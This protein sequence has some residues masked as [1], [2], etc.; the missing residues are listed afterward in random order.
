MKKVRLCVLVSTMFLSLGAA[1]EEKPNAYLGELIP[2]DATF[3]P[4]GAIR[5]RL[6]SENP[7][8]PNQS[9]QHL[10]LDTLILGG[11]YDSPTVFGSIQWRFY[12]GSYP[13]VPANGYTGAQSSVGSVNFPQEAYLGYKLSQD[14]SVSAGIIETPFGIGRFWDSTFY[15]GLGN[16][17]GVQDAFNLGVKYSGKSGPAKYDVA[18]LAGDAGNFVGP[19]G[20]DRY[21]SN[22]SIPGYTLGGSSRN[23]EKSSIVGRYTYDLTTGPL[24]HTVGA[25]AWYG[26][27]RNADTGNT[28][29]RLYTALFDSINYGQWNA[30][31][32]VTPIM[33]RP[34]NPNGNNATV[35]LGGYDGS[36]NMAARGLATSADLSYTFSKPLGPITGITPY[37]NYSRFDKSEQ[38]F[39]ASERFITGVNFS[40]NKVYAAIEY[41]VGKNDPYTN[42]TYNYGNG[43]AKGGNNQW[44]KVLYGNVGYYF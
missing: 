42:V 2:S 19:Y 33:I 31:F 15:E 29:D 6:D 17:M 3:V 40:Y 14:S 21:S 18:Y 30:K 8:R 28:G 23:T 34:E 39:K 1:A 13:Y 4:N 24:K 37:F 35:T 27:V 12:G 32:Q 20:N 10:G 9:G 11:K 44:D 43:L 26:W 38:S 41:R 7:A 16:A 36:Y 5:F 25:S 22:I